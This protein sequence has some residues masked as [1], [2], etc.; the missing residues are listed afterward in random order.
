MASQVNESEIQAKTE[1]FDRVFKGWKS[2]SECR[3]LL[4]LLEAQ[5]TLLM[6][7][8]SKR[9]DFIADVFAFSEVAYA[10]GIVHAQEKRNAG[11]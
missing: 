6:L 5:L 2:S 4:P 1:A 8:P 3:R 7:D 11:P 10:A 9:D